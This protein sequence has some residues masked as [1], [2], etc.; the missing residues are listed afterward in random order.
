MRESE[1]EWEK[2]REGKGERENV[3][4]LNFCLNL[5]VV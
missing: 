5:S 3:C 4:S 2:E 1:K